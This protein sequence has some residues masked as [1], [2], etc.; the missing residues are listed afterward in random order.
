MEKP[1]LIVLI[2]LQG[3]GKST[4][5]KQMVESN[6]NMVLLSSDAVRKVNPDWDNEKVFKQL[7]EDMNTLL[8]QGKSVIMDATHTSSKMR[9]TLLTNVRVDRDKVV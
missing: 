4:L 2:G 3:S 8:K 7:Y 5:A 6:P 1:E 9:R